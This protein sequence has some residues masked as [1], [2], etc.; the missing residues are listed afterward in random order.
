M[1]TNAEQSTQQC[2]GNSMVVILGYLEWPQIYHGNIR[3]PIYNCT[4]ECQRSPR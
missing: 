2:V 3:S 1:V 4:G